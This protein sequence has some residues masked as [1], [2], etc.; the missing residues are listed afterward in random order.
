MRWRWWRRDDQAAEVQEAAT[1]RQ[2]QEEL[3]PEVRDV[4]DSLRRMRQ[5]NNF[6]AMIAEAL[7]GER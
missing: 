2:E 4:A 1:R 6:G 3:W 5:R 7:R